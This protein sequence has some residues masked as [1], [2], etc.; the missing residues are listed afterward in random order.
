MISKDNWITNDVCV[1]VRTFKL[2]GV[3]I[4]VE[5]NIFDLMDW[6]SQIVISNAPAVLWGVWKDFSHLGS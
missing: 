6:I 1:P 4:S 3:Y 5:S 2:A